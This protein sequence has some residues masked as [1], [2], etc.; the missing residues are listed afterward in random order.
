MLSKKVIKFGQKLYNKTITKEVGQVTYTNVKVGFAEVYGDSKNRYFVSDGVAV[1]ETSEPIEGVTYGYG[2]NLKDMMDSP[3][4][5]WARYDILPEFYITKPIF[6]PKDKTLEIVQD[7]I[8]NVAGRKYGDI[9]KMRYMMFYPVLN[10]RYVKDIVDILKCH[11]MT[12]ADT[13]KPVYDTKKPVYFYEKDDFT[14]GM[15]A[16]LMPIVDTSVWVGFKNVDTGK[17]YNYTGE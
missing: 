9:V 8:Y 2:C 12:F 15:K 16:A 11:K 17:E 1:L 7:G 10:A 13:K 5:G 6:Y 14:H 4:N 3:V